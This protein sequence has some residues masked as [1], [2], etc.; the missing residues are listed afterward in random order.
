MVAQKMLTLTPLRTLQMELTSPS[1]GRLRHWMNLTRTQSI[2]AVARVL[3][4]SSWEIGDV[5]FMDGF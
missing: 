3:S 2:I 5:F 1:G 4:V